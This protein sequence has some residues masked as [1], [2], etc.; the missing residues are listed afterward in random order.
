MMPA[1]I[2]DEDNGAA[3]YVGSSL[4]M[5]QSFDSFFFFSHIVNKFLLARQLKMLAMLLKV[6]ASF[7]VAYF[8]NN[9]GEK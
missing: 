5:G 3:V 6:T 1:Q 2:K 9:K 7:C 4:T 8:A